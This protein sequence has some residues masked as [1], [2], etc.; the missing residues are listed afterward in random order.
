MNTT[1][2]SHYYPQ[3]ASP[4][5]M[6]VPTS[7]GGYAAAF[8]SSSPMIY[9]PGVA[10]YT[11]PQNNDVY[12]NFTTQTRQEALQLDRASLMPAGSLGYPMAGAGCGTG[13]CGLGAG[14]SFYQYAPTVPQIDQYVLSAG[15]IRNSEMTRNP[16]SRIVGQ[17]S[18][19]RTY[20]GAPITRNAGVAFYDSEL[21][22]DLVNQVG[23]S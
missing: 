3:L 10:F 1:T 21:R 17:P 16:T 7:T 8:S 4:P 6:L 15:E 19:L 22:L 14:N 18:L 13:S 20:P 5:E 12:S 11:P 2:T 23:C 9:S